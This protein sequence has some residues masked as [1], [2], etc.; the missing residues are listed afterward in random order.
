L[1]K[2]RTVYTASVTFV[3]STAFWITSAF[4]KEENANKDVNYVVPLSLV[5]FNKG[6]FYFVYED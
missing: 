2:D 3:D 6:Y 5:L 4:V 1:F